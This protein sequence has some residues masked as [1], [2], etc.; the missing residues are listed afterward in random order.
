MS[1]PFG[2][3]TPVVRV[4]P[5]KLNLTLA[6]VGRRPDGYHDLHSVMAPLALA[7]LVS[8]AADGVRTRPAPRRRRG[9]RRGPLR[10]PDNLVLRAVAALRSRLGRIGET[11]PPLADPARE[12]D[13]GRGGARWRE[14]R[15][16]GRHRRRIR[17][18]APGPRFR[19]PRRGRGGRRLGRAVLLRG[20]TGPRLRPRRDRPSAQ[21]AD[22]ATARRPAD[23]AGRP[24]LDGGRLRRLRRGRRR[25]SGS[26]RL[27]S[28]HLAGEFAGA[29]RRRPSTTARASSR[30]PTTS[31][32]RRPR[33]RPTSSRS[34]GA[35]V[36]VLG[37]PVGQS[38]SGPTLWVLYP[39]PADAEE[40]A[41]V[42]GRAVERRHACRRPAPHR[43]ARSRRRSPHPRPS[44]ARRKALNDPPGR[45]QRR[46]P[47]IRSAPTARRSRSMASC[48]VPARSGSIR[49][50]ASSPR[51]SRRR[52]SASCR[53]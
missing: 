46:A 23:R 16:R 32:R 51:G 48:S 38:G 40:A 18:V 15:R 1:D 39:S 28:Q 12:A 30:P 35:L 9:P 7:D 2:R 27:T 3:L 8:L 20:G 5:A 10:G 19:H 4:A 50:P 36:R 43:P 41:A 53:T 11:L 45:D 52:P 22:R 13:P 42:I 33:S 31:R 26:T 24:D 49:P 37:R 17:G 25:G 29:S 14:Q 21:G 44:R 47:R 6:V 34:G